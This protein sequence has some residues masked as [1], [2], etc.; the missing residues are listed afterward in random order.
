VSIRV[1]LETAIAF[2]KLLIPHGLS[3]GALAH[4]SEEDGDDVQMRDAS[5]S[6]WTS[7]HTDAWLSFLEQRGVKGV[8]KDTWSMVSGDF[9]LWHRDQFIGVLSVSGL[10]ANDGLQI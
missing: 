6:G 5:D 8:S 9:Y 2:W 3:G 4:V 1:A 10:F 7:K